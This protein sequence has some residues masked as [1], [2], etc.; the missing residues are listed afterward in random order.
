M[1]PQARPAEPRRVQP[2]HVILGVGGSLAT[3][4]GLFAWT[5]TDRLVDLGRSLPAEAVALALVLQTGLAIATGLRVWLLLRPSVSVARAV[6]LSLVHS[7]FLLVAPWRTGELVYVLLAR[8]LAGR[9]AVVGVSHL[10]LLR[11]GDAVAVSGLTLV[12][13]A[14]AGPTIV[15]GHVEVLT[16]AVVL[17]GGTILAG[18]AGLLWKGGA[19]LRRVADGIRPL[20]WAGPRIA[21]ALE[22]VSSEFDLS[23]QEIAAHGALAVLTWI[24]V[25]AVGAVLLPAAGVGL[26]ADVV[27]LLLAVQRF[28][29]AIPLPALGTFGP[30]ELSWTAL[31]VPLGIPEDLAVASMMALHL[32]VTVHAWVL[33]ALAVLLLFVGGRGSAVAAG[34]HPP[35]AS[36]EAPKGG[37]PPVAG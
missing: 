18:A 20:R 13:L 15:P 36:P 27:V 12:L 26:P 30:M 16:T 6:S 10:F 11:L 24:L 21:R 9:A 34:S 37:S 17:A 22:G 14:V 23:R 5:G 1:H 3:L 4:G 7:A 31:V 28:V 19:F 8:R 32:L 33:A 29:L 35:D 25:L 2:L